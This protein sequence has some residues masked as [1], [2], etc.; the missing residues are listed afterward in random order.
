MKTK[1]KSLERGWSCGCTFGSNLHKGGIKE[2][3][4]EKRQEVNDK[5]RTAYPV[6]GKKTLGLVM[7]PKN[8]QSKAEEKVSRKLMGRVEKNIQFCDEGY[9]DVLRSV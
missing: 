3:G 2:E 6:V 9:C 7:E 1:D 4:R 5:V 8:E